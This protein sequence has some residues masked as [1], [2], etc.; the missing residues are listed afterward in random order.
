MP[1][2]FVNSGAAALTGL[3]LNDNLGAYAYNTSTLYPLT[4]ID[5]SIQYYINGVLQAAPTATAGPP[6]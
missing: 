1:Y 6:L 2:P 5:G 3:T 4:Y